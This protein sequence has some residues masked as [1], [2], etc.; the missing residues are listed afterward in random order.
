MCSRFVRRGRAAKADDEDFD[1][2]SDVSDTELASWLV[3]SESSIAWQ[4][5]LGEDEKK[6][7]KFLPP[8][9]VQELYHHYAATRQLIGSKASSYTWQQREV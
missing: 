2:A 9:N 5:F 1:V 8:G 6:M 3:K 7:T 4:M